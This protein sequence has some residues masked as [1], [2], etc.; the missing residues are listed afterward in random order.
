MLSITKCNA[1]VYAF[2]LGCIDQKTYENMKK[3]VYWTRQ[4][5]Y[6]DIVGN[7]KFFRT[8]F[9][10]VLMLVLITSFVKVQTS[11]QKN[12]YEK[13][14]VFWGCPFHA[15]R[16]HTCFLRHWMIRIL[17]FSLQYCPCSEILQLNCIGFTCTMR[18]L[19]LTTAMG[20]TTSE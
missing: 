13:C 15:Q 12:W 14:Y 19:W 17:V 10:L 3:K 9:N 11:C 7:F 20:K 1:S 18:N 16:C 2:L 4:R 5:H 6:S 8:F